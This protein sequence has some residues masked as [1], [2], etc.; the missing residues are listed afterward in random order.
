LVKGNRIKVVACR[1]DQITSENA[2]EAFVSV[3]L[4]NTKLGEI[5][6]ERIGS[7]PAA[8]PPLILI[9]L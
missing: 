7:A 1:R 6:L 4:N 5:P 3:N 8:T 2:A 9:A